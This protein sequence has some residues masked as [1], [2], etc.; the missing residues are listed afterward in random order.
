M[1]HSY[2]SYNDYTWLQPDRKV[3]DGGV[4][5]PLSSSSYPLEIS[6]DE[7]HEENDEEFCPCTRKGSSL[8]G[9]L[10]QE[11]LEN[12]NTEAVA[13]N[14]ASSLYTGYSFGDRSYREWS[15][16]WKCH[17]DPLLLEGAFIFS[18][19]KAGDTMNVDFM[20]WN[21]YESVYSVVYG[22]LPLPG[23]GNQTTYTLDGL[24]LLRY[25]DKLS[26][27]LKSL[28][29]GPLRDE[30]CLFVDGF[31]GDHEPFSSFGY[32]WLYVNGYI[33]LE[34]W[35][36]IESCLIENDLDVIEQG[37][38]AA[39]DEE[40][41]SK[42]EHEQDFNE[43]LLPDEHSKLSLDTDVEE[44]ILSI[45][46]TFAADPPEPAT[47][48][49]TPSSNMLRDLK[50]EKSIATASTEMPSLKSNDIS[51]LPLC[52]YQ[53]ASTYQDSIYSPG[54]HVILFWNDIATQVR[55][56]VTDSLETDQIC[57]RKKLLRYLQGEYNSLEA[58]WFTAVSNGSVPQVKHILED[59]RAFHNTYGEAVMPLFDL[60]M[61]VDDPWNQ[62]FGMTGLTIAVV[63][64]DAKLVRC[65]LAAGAAVDATTSQGTAL[66]LAAKS[67]AKSSSRQIIRLLLAKGA[68]LEDAIF[69]LST[70]AATSDAKR[71]Q[72]IQTLEEL[73]LT[74]AEEMKSEHL[75]RQL[76]SEFATEHAH[77]S[78]IIMKVTT[79]PAS[80]FAPSFEIEHVLPGWA[81]GIERLKRP[82]WKVGMSI[83]RK[84]TRGQVSR[85]VGETVMVLTILKS[86]S[87]VLSLRDRESSDSQ[88]KFLNDLARWQW[89]FSSE[90]GSLQDFRRAAL[91]LWG[92]TLT[93]DSD[94][95][96]P[97]EVDQLTSMLFQVMAMNLM[98]KMSPLLHP[99]GSGD[100]EE[101]GLL[102]S[103]SRWKASHGKHTCGRR[104]LD[105]EY[106]ESAR[107]PTFMA[108]GCRED[109]P[110]EFSRRFSLLQ[111][112]PVVTFEPVFQSL[113]SGAI[114]CIMILFFIILR[115]LLPSTGSESI[116]PLIYNQASLQKPVLQA[117]F[118]H[119][120]HIL[121]TGIVLSSEHLSEMKS[122]VEVAINQGSMPS[123]SS[124]IDHLL[125]HALI[126][127]WDPFT[128]Q[129]V[130]SQLRSI[131]AYW[132]STYSVQQNYRALE[133]YL[134]FKQFVHIVPMNPLPTLSVHPTISSHTALEA[135]EMDVV[136]SNEG[137]NSNI[138][139]KSP[140]YGSSLSPLTISSNTAHSSSSN[141]TPR[142][143][144][145]S[146]RAPRNTFCHDCNRDYGK[147]YNY[148][149][150]RK[151]KHEKA[152]FPCRIPGCKK[153][154]SRNHYRKM[155]E[156]NQH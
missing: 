4:Q 82:A 37:V 45:I 31:L 28:E 60:D 74:P 132:S 77:V 121:Q 26:S 80:G 24:L 62:Y 56:L 89:I 79:P 115:S 12:L 103:Q 69:V 51:P 21:L 154:L 36:S 1:D 145:M 33:S 97:P 57:H 109:D 32:H 90:D 144:N 25:Y 67:A 147:V 70:E 107:A 61:I 59:F 39:M 138:S 114:F 88:A 65:L 16:E 135:T 54:D 98:A 119:V 91:V 29:V 96:M 73:A 106:G 63:R 44:T 81:H 84:L 17:P 125:N 87:N 134:G 9:F 7:N 19:R 50:A 130:Q 127:H 104:N 27:V 129:N 55:Y 6:I 66:S 14:A 141:S 124:L 85:K 126:S 93:G 99:Q 11:Q 118:Q 83:L 95:N 143:L 72:A 108:P 5:M 113:A 18:V 122:S 153:V 71:L 146:T 151:D 102:A 42:S 15:S 123:F 116:L 38:Q 139:S 148:N 105:T 22:W 152:E 75:L 117:A 13:F 8:K 53:D 3:P 128:T 149:K 92:V 41:T 23:P 101:N 30:L 68:S 35:Q 47:S 142:S 48:S 155:H 131:K 46:S 20:S 10:L 136:R 64:G 94:L 43:I 150:H 78:E 40:D 137:T 111:P 58:A 110:D 112:T 34:R 156:K 120:L 140:T 76:H 133:V 100:F 52:T 49:E 86:M 2:F